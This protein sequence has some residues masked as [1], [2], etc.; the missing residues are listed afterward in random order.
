MKRLFLLMILLLMLP[1]RAQDAFPAPLTI[2]NGRLSAG[3]IQ[4]I[5]G[6]CETGEVLLGIGASSPDGSYVLV[7]TQPLIVVDALQRM[8]GIGGAPLPNNYWLCDQRTGSARP[9]AMQP[10][11]ANFFVKNVADRVSVY[12]PPVFSPDGTAIYWTAY[13]SYDPNPDWLISY[14][15]ASSQRTEMP[16]ALLPAYGVPRPI[17]LA[18][19]AQALWFWGSF[20]LS[21]NP[22]EAETMILQTDFAGTLQQQYP[23]DILLEPQ[24][25][26]RVNDAGV[27]K[28]LLIY[29]DGTRE[30][31]ILFNPETGSAAPLALGSIRVTGADSGLALVPTLA[32]DDRIIWT[33]QQDGAA[34]A[35]S[36]G[37]AL[38]LQTDTLL[39]LAQLASTGSD[40]RVL[41]ALAGL[42]DSTANSLSDPFATLLDSPANRRFLLW[43]AR[44]WQI[45]Q[46]V[47]AA[48][49]A[50]PDFIESRLMI[51]QEG[52]VMDS[53]PNRIR[54]EPALNGT[55]LG[56]IEGGDS[57]LVLDGPVCADGYA[58]WQVEYGSLTGWTVEGQGSEYWLEPLP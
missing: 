52:R 54:S 41:D 5:G 44:T 27:D 50:C 4:P 43:G 36:S 10:D 30:R 19:T 12:A 51:G 39:D 11:G 47:A 32:E 55:Y 7:Q 20:V 25:V 6:F 13:R 40:S 29:A 58:W 18:V 35:T 33:L 2:N 26:L 14:N 8:G 57:F 34:L 56:Q 46:A 38:S 3:G 9:L 16:L 42:L 1:V 15:I 28:L 23:Q 17:R 31:L 21:E 53:T 48:A 24:D 49:F 37:Q 45:D 22:F